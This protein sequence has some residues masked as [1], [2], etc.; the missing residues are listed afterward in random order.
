MNKIQLIS[1][2]VKSACWF[3]GAEIKRGTLHQNFKGIPKME[4]PGEISWAELL[5]EKAKKH[6]DRKYLTYENKKFSYK[7]MDNNANKVANFLLKHGG[8]KGKG[9]SIFMNNSPEFLD[10]FTGTQKIGMYSSL[11]STHLR[12]DSLL[13]ILNLAETEF[14]IIDEYLI[15]YYEKIADR[16]TNIKTVFVLCENNQPD[17][18]Y[19]NF[20]DA[21]NGSTINP[22]VGYNKE[23]ICF[24]AY[25]SGTTGM[26]KGVVFK[27]RNTGI[28]LYS[29]MATILYRRNDIF[30]TCLPLFHAGALWTIFTMS[31]SMGTKL[32]LAKRFS[33]S[34]FW[35]EIIEHNIT[36]FNSIGAMLAIET[37]GKF[38]RSIK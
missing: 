31:L 10:V 29:F 25:T 8:N 26:P 35:S 1:R 16:L 34:S 7:D 20:H 33:A 18:K 13:Q 14:L 15:N 11:V 3:I 12:G 28:K 36:T 22:N 24:I 2:F 27:Y 32:V 37:T 4:F 17:N 19:I 23:D 9:I 21:Y 38:V 5:E 30:Y 6:P